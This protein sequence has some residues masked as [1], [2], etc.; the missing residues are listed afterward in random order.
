MKKYYITTPIYYVN[1]RP[2]I[3]HA[4]TTIAADIAA[5]WKRLQNN[6]VYFLTGT[7]EHGIKIQK[8]SAENDV[9]PKEF[10]DMNSNKF[11]EALKA[12]DIGYSKFI[13]TTDEDH[14]KVVQKIFQKLFANYCLN[15]VRYSK[16][17]TS[18]AKKIS[19]MLFM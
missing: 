17:T 3:G 11:K 14:E 12:L 8:T 10:C 15:Y 19:V 1:D 4:Y 16:I 9:S 7:D 5:R 13:R 18:K 2:H 6:E